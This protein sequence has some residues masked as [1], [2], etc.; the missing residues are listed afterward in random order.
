[1][2]ILTVIEELL[3]DFRDLGVDNGEGIVAADDR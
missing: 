1:M 2:I 3:T